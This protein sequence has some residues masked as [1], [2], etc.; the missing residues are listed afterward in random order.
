MLLKVNTPI[1]FSSSALTVGLMKT[2]N[3]AYCA[4]N[5]K[6]TKPN[7]VSVYDIRILVYVDSL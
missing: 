6:Y 4:F 2:D 7:L 3:N 5:N 1:W